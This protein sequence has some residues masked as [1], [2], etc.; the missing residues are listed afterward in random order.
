M[1]RS[2]RFPRS[3]CSW[4]TRGCVFDPEDVLTSKNPLLARAARTSTYSCFDL[5]VR[6]ISSKMK[7]INTRIC[8]NE[9]R[10]EP[11]GTTVRRRL[12]LAFLSAPRDGTAAQPGLETRNPGILLVRW[13][14]NF[15]GGLGRYLQILPKLVT[16]CVK[17]IFS[18]SS[19]LNILNLS[20]RWPNVNQQ[21]NRVRNV[22]KKLINYVKSW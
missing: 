7:S 3:W 16:K 11:V 13:R 5:M 17:R 4:L 10:K 19:F 2:G 20:K 12:S 15:G 18:M 6:W 22:W 8:L 14:T 1:H 9:Q 21:L